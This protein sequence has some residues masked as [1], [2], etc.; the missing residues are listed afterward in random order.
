MR[1]VPLGDLTLPIDK[2]GPSPAKTHFTYV[3][4]SAVNNISKTIDGESITRI[5]AAPSRARQIICSDDVIVSTVRP[6]LNAVALVP[7]RLSGAIASTGFCVL[8]ARS[9]L[10]PRYLFHWVRCERFVEEMVKSATGA[11][12]PSVTDSIVKASRIPLPPI[13]EQRRIAAILDR[14]DALLSQTSR[15]LKELDELESSSYLSAI[16][17][18]DCWT[19]LGEVAE[20]RSGVGF[21]VALQGRPD[22]DYPVA[23]VGDIGQADRTN[24]PVIVSTPNWVTESDLATMRMTP[25]P[26]GSVLFAKIGEAI[27]LN[28][29]AIAGLPLLIDNNAMAA[30]PRE[31]SLQQFLFAFMKSVDLYPLAA[32]TTVPSLRKSELEKLPFPILSDEQ[33]LVF[34]AAQVKISKLR[35]SVAS[36]QDRIY[37]LYSGLQAQAFSGGL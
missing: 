34:E 17:S 15:V 8:R 28:N 24:S 27:R 16:E 6:N 11:S 22:G 13:E 3:D 37:Q 33:L 35:D 5:E 30:I 31:S 7:P 1:R 21:P 4:L 20:L 18:V 2:S 9:G 36:L 29:R 10:F 26:P 12:Y 19:S 25:I 23:K 14:T 32:A